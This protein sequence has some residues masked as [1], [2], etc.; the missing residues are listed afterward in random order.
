MLEQLFCA[1]RPEQAG[2]V[3]VL[4]TD[5][6][7]IRTLNREF[8]GIDRATDVLSFEGPPELPEVLGDIV[9]SVDT[10]SRQAAHFGH[11][12]STEIAILGLHGGLHLL[13]F[14]DQT[15]TDRQDM[16][17]RMGEVAAKNGIELPPDWGSMSYEESDP[18]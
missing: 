1:Y 11:S 18:A 5:D 17:H 16:V 12:T 2:E 3:S 15:D 10:A 9:I 13:G 6:A 7:E 8:R 4:L 14:D